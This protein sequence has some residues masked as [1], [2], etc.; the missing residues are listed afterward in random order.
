MKIS[1]RKVSTKSTNFIH[2]LSNCQIFNA[3]Y[4]DNSTLHFAKF[5]F[6]HYNYFKLQMTFAKSLPEVIRGRHSKA[7]QFLL[8]LHRNKMFKCNE[9]LKFVSKRH[10]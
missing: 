1:V 3:I 9:I 8:L 7:L 2:H 5:A 6:R 10:R 4:E